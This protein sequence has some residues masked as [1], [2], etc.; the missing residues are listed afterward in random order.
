MLKTMKFADTS[1]PKVWK[2]YFNH[3]RVI[4]Y[5]A[6]FDYDKKFSFEEKTEKINSAIKA[7]IN[8]IAG[9]SGESI[10]SEEVLA[11][12]PMYQWATYAVVNSLVDMVIPDVL[13]TELGEISEIR[14]INWGDS[15]TFDIKSSDLFTVTKAGNSRRH[16]AAQRQFT[17]QS[18]LTPEN[19][20]ITTQVDLYRVLAGKENL[21]E[22]AYKMAL[23]MAS[24]MATDAYAALSGSYDS[25]TASFKEAAFTQ[26]AWTSLANRVKAAN[27]GGR[28]FAWGTNAALSKVLPDSDYL[29]IGL[30]EAYN[31]VGYLPIYL[32]VPLL[33]LEQKIDWSSA[34]Y[35]FALNDDEIFFINSNENK[36]IKIVVEGQS[37]SV[38]DTQ[39][40]N[41]NLTMNNSV[42]KRW[43]VGIV[44]NSKF[45]ILK[46]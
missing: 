34:D 31:Q 19:H 14:N 38:Q 23:S 37:L 8:K 11:A 6:K 44:T 41:A 32:N 36:I 15:A 2:D 9:L 24:E 33:A 29:K 16:V 45:G 43:K 13:I 27:G 17:G 42:H 22:Y 26:T 10:V 46:V 12:S 35:S 40:Q 25:L 30:G 5:S 20:I 21:A 4:Q 1:L 3:Y 7:E 28:V 39:F 18:T